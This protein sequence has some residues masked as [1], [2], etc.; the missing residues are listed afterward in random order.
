MLTDI[1]HIKSDLQFFAQGKVLDKVEVIIERVED[2]DGDGYDKIIGEIWL[3]FGG[4]KFV[5]K[6]GTVNYEPDIA[7]E[8]DI[9]LSG[10]IFCDGV[11]D[12]PPN[13]KL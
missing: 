1:E 13:F 8:L 10:C 5:I 6:S 12:I 11:T 9:V 4:A 7:T 3:F 2:E